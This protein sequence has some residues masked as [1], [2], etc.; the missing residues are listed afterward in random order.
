MPDTDIQV[1]IVIPVYNEEEAI[2]V[3]LRDI[4]AVMNPLG[5]GYEVIVVDDGSTDKTRALC[6]ADPRV[7]LL[8][9]QRNRGNG[10]ARTTG[11]RHAQGKYVVMTDA[12]GTYPA[13]AIPAM[14]RELE[15]C[16]MVTGA[17]KRE[18]GTMRLLRTPAKNFIRG[19]AS[20]LTRTPIPDLNSGLRAMRRDVVMEFLPILPETHSWVSTITMAMLS[21]NYEV[22]WQPIDYF[23]RIG[24]SKFDPITDTYNYLT[25]SSGPSCTSIRC[26]SFCPDAG[27]AVAGGGQGVADVVRFDWHIATSTVMLHPHRRP[28]SGPW[29]CWP[30]WWPAR[31]ICVAAGAEPCCLLVTRKYPPAVGGIGDALSY[32][33]D[34]TDRGAPALPLSGTPRGVGRAGAVCRLCHR[35]TIRAGLP[36]R[37]RAHSHSGR[38]HSRTAGLPRATCL[39]YPGGLQRPRAGYHLSTCLYQASIIGALKRLRLAICI[40]TT[41]AT[42]AW[43]GECQA[44]RCVVIPPGIAA[45]GLC[46]AGRGA[47][48]PRS[49]GPPYVMLRRAAGAQ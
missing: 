14:L 27:P 5:I 8:R 6:E 25:W 12:D 10:A 49:A 4:Y 38:S 43:P 36:W 45:A 33:I 18:M 40:R 44:T 46:G 34:S 16:D 13:A 35:K 41:P 42:S 17:R 28:E 22:R 15:E 21:S 39:Q 23:K 24:V 2:E 26:A 9:H 47:T 29:A 1:S 11:M 3:V 48:G 32:T 37:R 7:I 19:L 20:Y 30:T 31:R